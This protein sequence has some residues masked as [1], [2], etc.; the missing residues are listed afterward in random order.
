MNGRRKAKRCKGQKIVVP[1][2]KK[3]ESAET[4]RGSEQKRYGTDDRVRGPS[5]VLR[6]TITWSHDSLGADRVLSE[7]TADPRRTAILSSNWDYHLLTS[8][9]YKTNQ[10]GASWEAASEHNN[11]TNEDKFFD[12]PSDA[13]SSRRTITSSKGTNLYGQVRTFGVASVAS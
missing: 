10:A 2:S 12:V 8:H 1:F 5:L 11:Q 3:G 7:S 13:D 4:H 9:I 6:R